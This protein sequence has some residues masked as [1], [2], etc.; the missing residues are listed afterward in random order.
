MMFGDRIIQER[1][2]AYA[3]LL[4]AKIAYRRAMLQMDA[5]AVR[6]QETHGERF[7]GMRSGRVVVWRDT[8]IPKAGGDQ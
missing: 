7:V 3:R 1:N 5:R 6:A 8:T 2:A 4:A